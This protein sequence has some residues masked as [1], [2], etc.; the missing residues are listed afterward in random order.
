MFNPGGG[1]HSNDSVA[2]VHDQRNAKK[3]CV[4]GAKRLRDLCEL[5]LG[6]K[7]AITER[8]LSNSIKGHLGVIFHSTK[9]VLQKK[10]HVYG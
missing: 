10:K 9:H 5:Q 6:F 2:H 1:G 4:W 3:G 8:V 7:M